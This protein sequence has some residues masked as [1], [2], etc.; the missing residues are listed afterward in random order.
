MDYQT[1]SPFYDIDYG[2]SEPCQ[3]TD[4]R[5]IAARL[6]PPLYSL[7]F[8]SGFVGNLLV[9]LVL[10]KCKKLKSMTD[11]Y[12]LNLAI[13]D[14]LFLLTLPF[15]AHYAA[16]QWELG[17]TMCRLLTGLYFIGFFSGIFFIILLTIDRYLAIVHAVFALKARTVTFGLMTSG[18]TWA[19][20]VFV[21]LPGIIFTK[22]QKEG[23]RFTCSPHYPPSQYHFWR[24]F[25]AL[26]MTILGLVLPL[27][28]MIICYSGILKTLLR[29][30]NE[31]KRHKA[32]RLIFVIMIMYF[33]FWAPYNIVLLLSTFQKSFGL[34][35]C[36]SSNRLDQAM[37][38]TETL[39]M[40]HCCINP[41]IYA[42]V[43]EKFRNYLLG[44][45][46]K[47]IVRRFCK[48]CPVFQGEA[49][50]RVN[51]IYTGSTGEQEISVGL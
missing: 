41:V 45:F 29:C 51:S 20:A 7:V 12:L 31:K 35:Q 11:I 15:W 40:T 1:T 50:K 47:H 17:N 26:K 28:V 23:T 49:P 6:L 34:D 4:V 42:F 2:M 43:G 21:S 22:S 24:N 33:L 5:Q 37:Q 13:S 32:V 38:V 18:V 16:H 46:R 3:K 48:S 8:I 9:A 39:G 36:S 10:I 14:L 30:R 44:Y 27:L 25:Q 19:V